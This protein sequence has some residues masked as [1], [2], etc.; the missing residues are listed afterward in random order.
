MIALLFSLLAVQMAGAAPPVHG[1]TQAKRTVMVQLFEWPWEAVAEA[2]GAHSSNL[3]RGDEAGVL[4]DRD[5]LL[6]PRQRHAEL[7]GKRGDRGILSPQPLKHAPARR[8]GQRSER[9][10]ESLKIIVNHMVQYMDVAVR[11]QANC[12]ATLGIVAD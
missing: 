10:V 3:L 9:L 2:A 4:E 7:V 1:E 11:L 5:V 12:V 6:H 8:I